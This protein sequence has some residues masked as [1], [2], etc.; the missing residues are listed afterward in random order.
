MRSTLI[1]VFGVL[2]ISC[3]TSNSKPDEVE[4]NVNNSLLA[5]M[6]FKSK[7]GFS[8]KAPKNWQLTNEYNFE[9]KNQLL[10]LD[11]AELLAVYKSDSSNCALIISESNVDFNS[12][13]SEVIRSAFASKKD[14]VWLSVQPSF[15][16]YKRFDIVQFVYQNSD[17]L[18]FRLFVQ[19][20]KE[21]HELYYIIP[22]SDINKTVQSVESSIGS[23]S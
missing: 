2:L 7:A 12:L 8:I 3:R 19:G 11:Q 22:R 23:I 6:P 10:N 16:T 9:F 5:E 15:F 13:K 18:V 14:S 21:L 17:L 1:F 20:L 4:F